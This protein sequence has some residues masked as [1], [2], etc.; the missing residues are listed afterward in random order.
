VLLLLL[1]P[2]AKGGDP[3]S[4]ITHHQV[5]KNDPQDSL[6]A[7]NDDGLSFPLHL[8]DDGLQ[9]LDHVQVGLAAG[10]PGPPPPAAAGGVCIRCQGLVNHSPPK[11]SIAASQLTQ[12][13]CV[14]SDSASAR[15]PAVDWFLLL[16]SLDFLWLLILDFSG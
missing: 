14:T 15:L 2:P 16:S 1:Y 11:A 8:A 10:V 13:P 4:V 12:M 3:T 6:V 7:D 5:P 9:A